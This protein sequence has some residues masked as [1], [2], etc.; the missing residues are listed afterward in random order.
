MLFIADCSPTIRDLNNL[1]YVVWNAYSRLYDR[2]LEGRTSKSHV[3]IIYVA[4]SPTKRPGICYLWFRLI[5]HEEFVLSVVH[6]YVST[7]W[8]NVTSPYGIDSDVNVIRCV[9]EAV[10]SAYY[11]GKPVP[12]WRPRVCLEARYRQG[13][14]GRGRGNV[15]PPPTKKKNLTR[16]DMQLGRGGSYR[17]FYCSVVFFNSPPVR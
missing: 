2:F 4:V 14:Y 16:G 10:S 9:S 1:W 7:P 11:H 17:V 13:L 15:P 8:P 5:S 6:T 12:I 3:Y